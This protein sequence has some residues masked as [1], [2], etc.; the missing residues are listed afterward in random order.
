MP[1]PGWWEALWPDPAKVLRDVGVA[2]GMDVVDLCSGDG[3]FTLPIAT[4]ARRV[5]V[6]D[7]DVAMLE[8]AK[9][10][11]AARGGAPSCTFV[12]A[13]AYDVAKVV[14]AP[15]DHVFL[16][17]AFH[18]VPDKSRLARAVHDALKPGGLFAIV[19][20]HARPREETIVL[21][22]PRG[23]ETRLRMTPE[24]TVASVEPSGLKFRKRVDVSP[25]HYGA[26]FERRA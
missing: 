9:V 7:I 6:V 20:W 3:W 25:Y 2:A 13:D 23:P 26:V 16:G 12:E 17:N 21:G 18:G 10:R 14:G 24:Q 4:M 5:V 22:E 15:V 11:L 1:D 19:S 8:A